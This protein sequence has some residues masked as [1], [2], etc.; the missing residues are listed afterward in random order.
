M[1]AKSEVN[2]LVVGNVDIV[3]SRLLEEV[4]SQERNKDRI[5]LRFLKL[6]FHGAH[7]REITNLDVNIFREESSASAEIGR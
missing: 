2:P 1:E 7:I 4:T 5:S 6:G 3:E